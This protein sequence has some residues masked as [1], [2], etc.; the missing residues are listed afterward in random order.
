MPRAYN[1][2]KR[3]GRAMTEASHKLGIK[4]VYEQPAPDD[5]TRVLVDRMW[6]RG[7]TKERAAVDVWVKDVAPSTSL[8]AW[9]SHDPARWA[10]FRRRYIAELSANADEVGRLIALMSAGK[11][12]LLFGAHD[13]EHNNAVA[14]AE[15]LAS[16]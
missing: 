6:P 7:L 8:R 11:T 10:E 2:V 5:G 4:R 9:F 16:H 3:H 1:R 12:T 15:Y 13:T 14:L